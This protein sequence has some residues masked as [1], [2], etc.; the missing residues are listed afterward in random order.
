MREREGEKQVFARRDV[1]ALSAMKPHR[2]WGHRR[3]LLRRRCR[4]ADEVPGPRRGGTAEGCRGR[5]KRDER[6]GRSG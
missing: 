5:E 3:E 4:G 6:W 2:C 1:N